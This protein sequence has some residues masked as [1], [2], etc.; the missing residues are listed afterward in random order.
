LIKTMELPRIPGSPLEE[1]GQHF[2]FDIGNGDALA[3]FWWQNSPPAAPGV[4]FP[5]T[6]SGQ[7]AIGS[8]H[9]VAFKIAPEQIER[10]AKLLEDNG[11][12]WY[13]GAH[14]LM[15]PEWTRAMESITPEE[16]AAMHTPGGMH[17]APDQVNEDTF[18]YSMY[19][20]DPDG[21]LLE[22][23]AWVLPAF[24][25]ITRQHQPRGSS[26]DVAV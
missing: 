14:P 23:C 1:G 10:T 24:D 4:A 22:F 16:M 9:H 19:F 11:I 6:V 2:F 17:Y 15:S 13:G 7:S 26:R 18:A 5:T 3:F 20:T 21:I 25:K 12:E 8:M